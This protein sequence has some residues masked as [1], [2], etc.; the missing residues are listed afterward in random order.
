[1]TRYPRYLLL[2]VACTGC[3]NG[4]TVGLQQDAAGSNIPPPDAAA[5]IPPDASDPLPPGIQLL[6]TGNYLGLASHAANGQI[7]GVEYNN[8]SIVAVPTRIIAIT[9]DTGV[10]TTFVDLAGDQR[11]PT[12][13][14]ASDTALFW[15]RAT[16]AGIGLFRKSFA[17]STAADPVV[18]PGLTNLPAGFSLQAYVLRSNQSLIYLILTN[19]ASYEL[20]SVAI[21][22]AASAGQY[23]Q[24]ATGMIV[25]AT[26]ISFLDPTNTLLI[27]GAYAWAIGYATG[28]N[29]GVLVKMNMT[30]HTG[31]VIQTV[32]ATHLRSLMSSGARF[33][34][35]SET[36]GTVVLNMLNPID[37]TQIGPSAALPA[38]TYAA[39]LGPKFYVT[40]LPGSSTNLVEVTPA[41]PATPPTGTTLPIAAIPTCLNQ[42]SQTCIPKISLLAADATSVYFSATTGV[43]KYTAP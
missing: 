27:S 20:G 21:G 38:N 18:V 25:G 6:A 30:L 43:Y 33:D 31:E 28:P 12:N 5:A 16:D 35:I 14:P 11:V 34:W 4:A 39:L 15:L 24:V 9:T 32:A 10:A 17:A 23:T 3:L 40:S 13:L 42:T 1:M 19:G 8:P 29:A 26:Q 7:Y 22:S 41:Q 36:A 2:A 37:L